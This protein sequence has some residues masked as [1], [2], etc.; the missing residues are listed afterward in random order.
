MDDSD[1]ASLAGDSRQGDVKHGVGNDTARCP[2]AS[3]F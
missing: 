3:R 2:S 1:G